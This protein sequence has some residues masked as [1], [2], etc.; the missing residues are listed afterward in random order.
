M[1]VSAKEEN[2][3][4]KDTLEKKMRRESTY[5]EGCGLNG[6]TCCNFRFVREMLYEMKFDSE[7]EEGKGVSHIV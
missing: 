1:V 7:L 3:V 5:S 2:K 4:E 6:K